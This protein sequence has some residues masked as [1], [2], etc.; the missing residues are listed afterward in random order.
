MKETCPIEEVIRSMNIGLLCVQEDP[1]DWPTMS[2]VVVLLESG[3][4]SLPQP[5]QPAFCVPRVI[6]INQ[7]SMTN[8]SVTG[9]TVASSVSSSS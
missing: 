3:S 6:P 4:V 7:S 8:R 5:S 9:L 2:S 1:A